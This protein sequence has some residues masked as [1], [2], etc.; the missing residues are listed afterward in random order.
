MKI[1]FLDIDGVLNS[2]DG[3]DKYGSSWIVDEDGNALDTFVPGVQARPIIHPENAA[4]LERIL[5]ADDDIRVVF[6]TSWVVPHIGL[7]PDV[8]ALWLMKNG[9]PSLAVYADDPA[10]PR[11]LSSSR[12]AEIRWWLE[13]HE[14]VK[15]WCAVD[16]IDLRSH[17]VK[18]VHTNIQNGL[19]ATAAD[20]VIELL[21]K[22]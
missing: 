8:L 14:D 11:K 5:S 9:V 1:L 16:D 6:S 17:L 4:Q 2:Y 19:T 10:T 13:D 7:T 21:K 18:A 3:H 12:S 15:H 20:R 22:D